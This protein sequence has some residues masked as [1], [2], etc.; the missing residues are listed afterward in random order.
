MGTLE[1]RLRAAAP[2]FMAGLR[3]YYRTIGI[4]AESA[5]ADCAVALV[6][7]SLS[8]DVLEPGCLSPE[9]LKGVIQGRVSSAARHPARSR[10]TPPKREGQSGGWSALATGFTLVE[11]MVVGAIMI[12]LFACALPLTR[13]V[14]YQYHLRAASS[15]AAL[16]IQATR[17]HAIMQSYPYQITF[18]AVTNTYQ[19]LSEVPPAAT[20]S[21]LGGAI[22]FDPGGS[23]TVGATTTF[24]FSPGGMVTVVGGSMPATMTITNP[25]GTKTIT[26]SGVGD[27]SITP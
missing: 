15:T 2:R 8:L 25:G 19:V 10:R 22:P 21:N 27:V 12:V 16:M 13:G 1:L 3:W 20:F 18:S 26:V 17:Y 23:S 5:D 4:R 9:V 14:F 7:G 6:R 24:Q 11:L